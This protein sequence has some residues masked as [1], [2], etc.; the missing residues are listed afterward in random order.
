M[1]TRLGSDADATQLSGATFNLADSLAIILFTPV[2][3]RFAIPYVERYIGR[4]VSLN[5]KI[6]AGIAF[7][8]GSQLVAAVIEYVRMNTEVLSIASHCAALRPDGQH[9]HM[10]SISAFWMSIPYAMIG[11]GEVLVNPVLQHF[12]YEGADPSMR[13]LLQAFNLF[14]MGGM[15]NA[16]S[17]AISQATASLTPNNLNNGNLPMV[18]FINIAFGIVLSGIYFWVSASKVEKTQMPTPEPVKDMVKI[19]ADTITE[20]E[21]N[22]EVTV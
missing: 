19:S 9:V 8:I 18:Y 5:M 6:Y 13:S 4:R 1:D 21:V 14:A 16:I 22:S 12:A 7:A 3:D 10:S 20:E 2:I 11:I 15:P 17:S